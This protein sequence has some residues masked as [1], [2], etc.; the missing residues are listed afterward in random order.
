MLAAL[1]T[2]LAKQ[3]SSILIALGTR[4]LSDT[5]PF[6]VMLDGGAD[7][8]QSH[9]ATDEMDPFEE[10]TWRVANPSWDYLP[11]LRRAS[12]QGCGES[13]TR[14]RVASIVSGLTSSIWELVMSL[15]RCF[16]R[17]MCGET[18]PAACT[19]DRSVLPWT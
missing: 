4:A 11:D 13:K 18:S 6:N 19:G 14:S 10:S 9:H 16:S 17:Q 2:Q 12:S 15:S 8:S 7:Y 5:H 3:P 1:T